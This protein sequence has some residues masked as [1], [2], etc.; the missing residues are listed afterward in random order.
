[1]AKRHVLA[2]PGSDPNPIGSITHDRMVSYAT[3]MDRGAMTPSGR[4]LLGLT[5]IVRGS[6]ILDKS[7]QGIKIDNFGFHVYGETITRAYFI[8]EA[9]GTLSMSIVRT[10]TFV[11]WDSKATPP[12]GTIIFTGAADPDGHE[13]FFDLKGHEFRIAGDFVPSTDGTYVIGEPSR[14]WKEIHTDKITFADSSSRTTA[15]D[16]FI[17]TN[18]TLGET[19]AQGLVVYMHTDGKVYKGTVA[20]ASQIIGVCAEAGVLNDSVSIAIAGQAVFIAGATIDEGDVLTLDTTAGRVVSGGTPGSGDTIGIAQ[21][22][23]TVG[24][25][26]AG[27]IHRS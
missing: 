16:T 20:K 23:A 17:S 15:K 13:V 19:V 2:G 24:N 3:D 9:D 25:G 5:Q 8:R 6:G 22:P 18:M 7:F 4:A 1:M 26:L 27:I 21:L 14:R 10:N 11:D 12:I